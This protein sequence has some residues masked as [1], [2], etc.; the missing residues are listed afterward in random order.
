MN[1]KFKLLV[2]F[3]VLIFLVFFIVKTL[4]LLGFL[5]SS[6]TTRS[7]EY[8][9]FLF[10]LPIFHIFIKNSVNQAKKA[11]DSLNEFDK[12]VD[13]SVLVS[14]TDEKG[15]ITYVNKKFTEV[16][17]WSLEEAIGKDHRIVNSGTHPKEFWT[18]MYR[19]TVKE[20]KIWNA[21]VT[22]LSK[23]G[24]LYWVDSYIKASFSPSGKLIGFMSIRY[25]VTDL[26]L[27]SKEI[28]KKNVYLE[29]AAKILRHDM[30]S[31]INTYMP[32]GLSSLERRLKPEDIQNLKIESPLKMIKEGLKHTQKVYKGVYEFTNLVK[33]DSCLNKE[34]YNLKEVLNDYL[35]LTSYKSLV[36]VCD[37]DY[38]WVNDAL[39][40]TAVDNL[41]RNGLKYNDSN[42]KKVKIYRVGRFIYIEDNGRGMSAEDFEQLQKP[43]V[44]KEGQ[45]ETGT[46]LGLNICIAILK[47]HGYKISCSKLEEGGTQLIIDTSPLI[48]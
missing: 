18:D 1:K 46:G 7:I 17:G 19:V 31:G 9:C 6:T 29:H 2:F 25:D 23:D 26:M 4:V 27:V 41:I 11:T 38:A 34:K 35:S 15:R 12:F 14:K 44:R 30:H 32:R 40:C 36:E 33:K 20:K 13:A 37:L 16:S 21:V 43:Y 39:F 28:E 3:A 22:N 10:L 47:E 5:Y 48:I 45:K 24:K 42:N 8:S